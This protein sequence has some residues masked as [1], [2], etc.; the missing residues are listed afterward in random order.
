MFA[1]LLAF[2]VFINVGYNLDHIL[3]VYNVYNNRKGIDYYAEVHTTRQNIFVHVVCMPFTIY[4][5]LYWIP[6][7]F[8]CDATN[9][10]YL[11]LA[12]F[13]FYFSHYFKIDRV[14]AMYF[15]LMYVPGV[16]ISA[17]KYVGGW[18]D[19]AFGLSM[20]A[21]VLGL[22]EYVGHHLGGD[23]PSRPEGVL[24]AIFYAMYFSA[25]HLRNYAEYFG[26]FDGL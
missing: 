7:V 12:L 26:V 23:P 24:N 6:A 4:G 1:T 14:T 20:S 19:F 8:L 3:D 22:Q 11:Q 9:A 5:M 10:F 18:G 13:L 21:G 17:H 16:F 2:S 25:E 15:A